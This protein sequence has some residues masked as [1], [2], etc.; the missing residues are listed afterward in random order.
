MRRTSAF[1]CLT[2]V[3]VLATAAQAQ[4]SADIES[5]AVVIH[6]HYF[7]PARAHTIANEL[8]SRAQSEKLDELT[9][10]RK[11]AQELTAILRTYDRHFRVNYEPPEAGSNGTPREMRRPYDPSAFNYGFKRAEKL[12]GNVALIELVGVADIDFGNPEDPARRAADAALSLAQDADAVILDLRANGGGAP[13][14]VG[15]LISAFV[16]PGANVYNTFHS[17]TGTESER[18]A[19]EYPR[20]MLDVPL[21]VLTSRRTFSA[22]ES[23]AFSLQSCGR[24][25]TVGERSGGG[26]NPGDIFPL[27]QGYS[28]FVSTGSPRNPINGRNWETTGVTPDV[29][30]AP[31]E[32]LDRALELARKK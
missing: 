2:A 25:K 7:D 8:R 9:D 1:L 16:K 13:S 23:I 21:F 22:A 30:T 15:Y 5:I 32:A 27:P 6:D 28:V 20:P 3:A 14:M 24:A 18:P 4:M 11:L 19:I 26:A 31:E 29:E 12:P 17:R 10:R